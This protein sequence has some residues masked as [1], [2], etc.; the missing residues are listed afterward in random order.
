MRVWILF[1]RPSKYEQKSIQKTSP[2]SRFRGRSAVTDYHC[3]RYHTTT[4]TRPFDG[5]ILAGSARRDGG[6]VNV[7]CTVVSRGRRRR[8]WPSAKRR[9]AWSSKLAGPPPPPW[10][11]RVRHGGSG[12]DGLIH[13]QCVLSICPRAP[14]TTCAQR[15]RT[16]CR[17]CAVRGA[18]GELVSSAAWAVRHARGAAAAAAF[19]FAANAIRPTAVGP[20]G[21]CCVRPPRLL[22]LAVARA[23][24]RLVD[25]SR[26]SSVGRDT[27]RRRRLPDYKVICRLRREIDK[28]DQGKNKSI[29]ACR[30][31]KLFSH[32][33]LPP[34]MINVCGTFVCAV[35]VRA[36]LSPR[37]FSS[38]G[39]VRNRIYYCCMWLTDWQTWIHLFRT[40]AFA[41]EKASKS[42]LRIRHTQPF[43]RLVIRHKIIDNKLLIVL[44]FF[45]FTFA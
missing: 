25:A 26:S 44:Y 28:K 20:T 9:R 45:F 1:S 32:S 39:T 21:H 17:Q 30:T 24:D 40:I 19:V 23:R 13:G 2:V 18:P 31:P 7:G 37:R 41:G 33:A 27:R 4:A 16:A 11:S 36:S 43:R 29:S 8:P 5:Q 42:R 38:S 22:Q 3:V 34:E 14:S 10:R 6:A 35:H 12:R 15:P